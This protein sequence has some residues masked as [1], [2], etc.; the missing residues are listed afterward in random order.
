MGVDNYVFQKEAQVA[1]QV[2]DLPV[3][4]FIGSGT[5]V[6]NSPALHKEFYERISRRGYPNLKAGFSLYPEQHG[7]DAYAVFK[8]G[9]QFIFS[10]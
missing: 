2:S 7:T 5:Y 1:A 4:L 6:G 9:I 3:T 10:N 8:D